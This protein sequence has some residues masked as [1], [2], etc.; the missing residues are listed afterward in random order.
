MKEM[1]ISQ[2]IPIDEKVGLYKVILEKGISLHVK[3]TGRS[4]SPY[5]RGGRDIDHTKSEA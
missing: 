1:F 5:L 3:V 2:A 4:M